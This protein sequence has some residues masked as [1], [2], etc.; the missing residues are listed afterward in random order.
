MNVQNRKLNVTIE[1]EKAQE[2]MREAEVLFAQHLPAGS[3]SRA[4][5]GAFHAGKALLLTEGIEIRSHQALGRLLSLHFVK[6]GR[7]DT[8]FA[9]IVSKTQK[10]REEADYTAEAVFTDA[11]AAECVQ[12]VKEWLE[13][14][15]RYLHQQSYNLSSD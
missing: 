13:A 2:A 12:E 11:N 5:Y 14:V 4:Y 8:R 3:I 10:F 15:R 1:W 7:F 6:T 9:R